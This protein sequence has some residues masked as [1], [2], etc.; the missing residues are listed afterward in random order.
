VIWENLKDRWITWRTGKDKPTRDYAEWCEININARASTAEDRFK[1][2]KHVIKVDYWK[3]FDIHMFT[4]LK[5]ELIQYRWPQRALGDNMVYGILRGEQMPDGLFHLTDFGNED[6]VYVA[7]NN[8]K[9]ATIIAL[10][11]G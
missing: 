5:E 3:T 4:E 11:Y 10:L 7:T 6:R 2:F 1:N 9:D 8:S